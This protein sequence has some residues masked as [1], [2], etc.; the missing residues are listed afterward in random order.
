M[1]TPLKFPIG[2][3]LATPGAVE[4][5]STDD[6]VQGLSRH[7]AGDWGELCPEDSKLNDEALRFGGRLLSAY[8]SEQ[9]E[10]FWIITEADQSAT[11]LLLPSEY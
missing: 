10:K 1:D 7:I 4:A 5:L 6:L 2:H 3:V 8:K 11:T 9:G